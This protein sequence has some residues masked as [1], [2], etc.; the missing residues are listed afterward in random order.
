MWASPSTISD[1][2]ASVLFF[3][4]NLKLDCITL[5]HN[6]RFP[7]IFTCNLN[8]L[9]WPVRLCTV[10]IFCLPPHHFLSITSC[11]IMLHLNWLPFSFSNIRDPWIILIGQPE[12]HI[13]PC[14][15]KVKPDDQRPLESNRMG[16]TVLKK[17]R[18]NH[19]LKKTRGP[20]QY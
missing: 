5:L 3:F 9:L 18:C 20:L 13:H 15:G 4:L 16:E 19:I 10:C 6:P 12:W 2:A 14:E 7:A 11:L 1:L 8:F 17:K